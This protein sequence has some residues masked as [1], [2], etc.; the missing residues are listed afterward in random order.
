VIG[1]T[2]KTHSSDRDPGCGR[3]NESNAG[4][5]RSLKTVKEQQ[6]THVEEDK[7]STLKEGAEEEEEEK[8][9]NK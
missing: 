2:N 6:V 9:A 1:L 7:V 8:I 3:T 4:S 5:R